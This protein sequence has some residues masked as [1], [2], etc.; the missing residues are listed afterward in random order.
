MTTELA[1]IKPTIITLEIEGHKLR[2]IEGKSLVCVRDILDAVDIKGTENWIR[3]LTLF[4]KQGDNSSL[5]SNRIALE[6][7]DIGQ[8]SPAA[9]TNE[10]GIIEILAGSRKPIAKVILRALIDKLRTRTISPDIIKALTD[11]IEQLERG[12]RHLLLQPLP[13]ILPRARLNMIIRKFVAR[14]INLGFSY[15]YPDAWRELYY[16][17]KYRYPKCDLRARARARTCDPLDSATPK[18]LEDLVNLAAHIFTEA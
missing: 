10:P 15:S 3:K 5:F 8:P 7:Y 2:S 18:E 9:F 14:Q 6:Y 13:D 1:L 11:R 4:S 16:Q 17:F 12:G